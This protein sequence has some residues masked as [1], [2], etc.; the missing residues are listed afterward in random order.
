ML[1]NKRGGADSTA[2]TMVSVSTQTPWSYLNDIRQHHNVTDSQLVLDDGCDIE[3]KTSQLQ[4]QSVNTPVD[5]EESEEHPHDDSSES[6]VDRTQL[7]DSHVSE[8]VEQLSQLQFISSEEEEKE[9]EEKDE[10]EEEKDE[11]EEEK[12]EEG[13]SGMNDDDDAALPPYPTISSSQL[14][15]PAI[16][17]YLRESESE[18]SKYFSLDN[19]DNISDVK[20][21]ECLAGEDEMMK[22]EEDAAL[23]EKMNEVC[24]FCGQS[25]TQWSVLNATT[26]PAE[27]VCQ[28]T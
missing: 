9:E 14:S 12:E 21:S 19:T 13:V 2:E 5:D 28:Y 17:Q 24:D 25:T 10:G 15:W 20:R 1:Q 23:V 18:A 27:P 6:V 4:K 11:G 16:L 7:E 8:V 26:A 3:E 22:H